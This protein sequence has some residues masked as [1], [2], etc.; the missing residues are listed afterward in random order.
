V[1]SNNGSIYIHCTCC[2]LPH[3]VKDRDGA[4]PQMCD[5]CHRHQGQLPETRALRA[6]THEAWLRERLDAC[7]KSEANAQG[8]IRISEG[9]VMEAQSETRRVLHS[10]GAL[11]LRIVEAV[12]NARGHRCDSQA[13]GRD[14]WVIKVADQHRSV[15]AMNAEYSPDS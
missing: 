15:L 11:A 14:H 13:V 1:A 4:L 6:E 9:R 12:D 7:R 3:W 10:R 5:T 2:K 8:R